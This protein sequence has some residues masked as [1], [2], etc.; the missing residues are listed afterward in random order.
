MDVHFIRRQDVSAT[1][2]G[3]MKAHDRFYWAVAWGSDN[4]ALS[5]L[6]HYKS[7]IGKLV[8][9]THFYQTPPAFLEQFK[10]VNAARVVPPDGSTFHPKTYLFVSRERSV[11]LI[12][13]ANFTNSAMESNVESCCLIGGETSERLF[14]DI[15][16]FIEDDCWE[17][18]EIIDSN[19][20]R[21]YRIQ[22]EATKAARAV[23]RK[24]SRLK[25]PTL[26]ASRVDPLEMNWLDF[27]SKVRQKNLENRLKVLAQS[28]RLL[29]GVAGFSKL[30]TIERKAIAGTA[31]KRES[32]PES[33][34]WG[35]FGRMSGFGV[36]QNL[37]NT[38]SPEIS[39]AMDCIPPTGAVTGDD[40][41]L[42]VQNFRNA[43]KGQARM[44][45]IP[46]ASRLLAMKRPDYF[47][48]IDAANRKGLCSHFGLSATAV[49]LENY[50]TDLIEPITLSSWWRAARPRG[51]DGRIW[52]GRSALLD[53]IFYDPK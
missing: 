43:F 35:A 34:D 37:I 5:E 33:P 17:S 2:K 10:N 46:S 49:N 47:V 13:S 15:Q 36:F 22:H 6:L 30:A 7:K 25:R 44:G 27:V 20:L 1:L 8:I 24:F 11:L 23:L 45:G 14:R 39:D 41:D 28:R 51:F 18:A 3:L 40:Y 50:W 52:D 31:G 38:N 29:D 4:P 12:G 32:G 9:G 21:A 26:S 42:F 48:C 19:F 53:A 16:K